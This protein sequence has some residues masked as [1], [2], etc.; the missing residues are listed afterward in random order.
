MIISRQKTINERI[1]SINRIF[2]GIQ[3]D[4]DIKKYKNHFKNGWVEK[5]KLLIKSLKNTY[6]F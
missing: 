4:I 3:I 6:L 5:H 1:E 2:S